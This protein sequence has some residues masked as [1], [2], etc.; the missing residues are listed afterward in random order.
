MPL[1]TDLQEQF[2]RSPRCAL[3][4]ILDAI[5][6]AEP[7]THELMILAINETRKEKA[8]PLQQR[9]WTASFLTGV[10]NKNGYKVG[11]TSVKD[12]INQEC[13]CARSA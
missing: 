10:L 4:K 9:L 8:L 11:A 6:R 3:G 2:Q 5:E 13:A 7:D 1:H 12:H